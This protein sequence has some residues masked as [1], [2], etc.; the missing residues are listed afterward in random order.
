MDA[1]ITCTKEFI[2]HLIKNKVVEPRGEGCFVIYTKPD[3]K[4]KSFTVE[5][6][7]DK[8]VEKLDKNIAE[9]LGDN[10]IKSVTEWYSL[11]RNAFPND[12]NKPLGGSDGISLR[13]GRKNKIIEGLKKR[14]NDGYNMQA[15]V[16]SV[17]YEVWLNVKNSTLANNKLQYMKRME[18]WIN[19]TENIDSMIERSLGSKTFQKFL[20]N[21]PG[22]TKRKIKIR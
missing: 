8:T 20:K 13:T 15:L 16:N 6:L 2:N 14:I 17:K 12:I 10:K 19:N 9:N 11:Y 18:A 5:I 22:G 7:Y 1:T 3:L 21:G 4:G